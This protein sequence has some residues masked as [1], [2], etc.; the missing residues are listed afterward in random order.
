MTRSQSCWGTTLTDRRRYPTRTVQIGKS[1]AANY[2]E[3]Y[4][5][6]SHSLL[7]GKFFWMRVKRQDARTQDYKRWCPDSRMLSHMMFKHVNGSKDFVA[8]NVSHID[9][10]GIQGAGVQQ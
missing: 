9:G 1:R 8:D 6:Y 10:H 3:L 7:S 4:V 5:S 2:C